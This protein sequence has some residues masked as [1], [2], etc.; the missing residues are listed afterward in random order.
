MNNFGTRIAN[1]R[2]VRG[3]SAQE[4]S[5]ALGGSPSR[6]AIANW[7]TGRRKDINVNELIAV[8]EV[9]EVA[10]SSICPELDA[11]RW[12]NVQAADIHFKEAITSAVS[13]LKAQL[14]EDHGSDS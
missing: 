5:D 3:L 4:L 13:A 6:S 8:A 9:L 11:N 7:E 1:Y 12:S 14:K 10:P 2:K